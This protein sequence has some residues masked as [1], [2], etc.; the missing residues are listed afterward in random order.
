MRSASTA[1]VLSLLALLLCMPAFP[2]PESPTPAV[3][4]IPDLVP[5]PS[6]SPD[7]RGGEG[8]PRPLPY[9]G[10]PGAASPSPADGTTG[11]GPKVPEGAST[12]PSP[13]LVAPYVQPGPDP[14]EGD[15]LLLWETTDR[16][17][18]WRVQVRGSL[19]EGWRPA[20]A[21]R[22]RRMA[23]PGVEPW[24]SW[25][26]SLAPLA[27]GTTAWYRVLRNGDVVFSSFARTRKTRS[28]AA[29][30]AI[31]GDAA[32]GTPEQKAIAWQAWRQAPDCMFI[33]GDVVYPYGRLSDYRR[34]FFPVYNAD[35]GSPATGAPLLRTVPTWSVV[36]NHDSGTT[37]RTDV[38]NLERFPD[39]L[40]WFLVWSLPLNGPLVSPVQGEAPQVLAPPATRDAFVQAASPAYPRMGNYSFDFG[41]TH[42]TVLDGNDYMDWTKPHLRA[43]VRDDLLA[44]RD[45]TWRLV[46]VHQAPFHSSSHHADEQRMRLLADVFEQGRV[47]VVLSGHV[48]D[49]ERSR[50]IRFHAGRL[51]T[52]AKG[53]VEGEIAVDRR[54][55]GRKET[56]PQGIIYIVTGAGGARLDSKELEG[57]PTTWQPYTARV[58]TRRHSMTLMDASDRSLV[59]RQLADDGSEVDQF[60][61]TR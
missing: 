5:T 27:T 1:L 2:S 28:Q 23:L 60:V 37:G 31:F 15:L 53:R 49:Y 36:G 11:E 54:Y 22:G 8:E 47:D 7:L 46:A 61:V 45:A 35:E 34:N 16:V 48:H 14:H 3:S 21:A 9:P 44:A 20:A 12:R 17:D 58:V 4:A 10:E 30:F 50:P 18:E 25:S 26:A 59:F 40:S 57:K 52:D 55:D 24:R 42:W 33:T 41:H 39:G 6:G 56:R 43:W 19:D 32:E 13:F 51:A 29:R 38:R